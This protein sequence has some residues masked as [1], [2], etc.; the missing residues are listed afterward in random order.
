MRGLILDLRRNGGGSL[1]EAIRVTGLFIPSGPVLQT[2][3][4]DHNVEV[5]VS[6]EAS[7]L[8]DG[9]LVVLTSRLSAS[10]SEIVAGALQDYGRGLLVGAVWGRC[11]RLSE[12]STAQAS[13]QL[14]G[15]APDTILPSETDLPDFGESKLPNALPWDILP[16]ANYTK[17]NMLG[18]I[19][20]RLREKSAARV[21]ADPGFRL[22][23]E[24]LAMVEKNAEAKFLSLNEADRRREKAQADAIQAEM[25]KVVLANAARMPPPYDVTLDEIDSPRFPPTRKPVQTSAPIGMSGEANLN[26]AIELSE[27]ENILADYIHASPGHGIGSPPPPRL[28]PPIR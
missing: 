24:E 6:P 15:V 21:T 16:P 9:P 23:R 25:K 11:I 8:Y 4:S 1:N 17:I 22:V 5:A 19:L 26:D 7:A 10:A 2:L 3:G 14:K 27:A 20:A 12:N 28:H 18:S 13:T